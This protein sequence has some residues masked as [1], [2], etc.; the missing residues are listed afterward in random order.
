MCQLTRL[1]QQ[2]D[3]SQVEDLLSPACMSM[4]WNLGGCNAVGGQKTMQHT[5]AM[6]AA[7]V[8]ARVKVQSLHGLVWFF[9]KA[10]S[11]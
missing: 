6:A 2:P 7:L 8:P 3:I 5:C 9:V 1:A 4:P 11:V 10:P